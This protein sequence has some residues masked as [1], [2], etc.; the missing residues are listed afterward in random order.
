MDKTAR[1]R[2]TVK[3]YRYALKVSAMFR[4]R[5]PL[6][7]RTPSDEDYLDHKVERTP[8]DRLHINGYVWASLLRRAAERIDG[9]PD[10]FNKIGKYDGTM[11]VSPFWFESTIVPLR[12][13]DI[14]P[15]IR[16]DRRLGTA[17]RGALYSE[18]IVPAGHKIP[19]DF[20]VFLENNDD[21]DEIV[22]SIEKI[23]HLIDD[24]IENIGGNW[25]YGYGRLRFLEGRYR[26]L[27][28]ADDDERGALWLPP[29]SG[30]TIT[31]QRPEVKSPYLKITVNARISD[32][33]MMAIHS[34]L[35]P[36]HFDFASE[37][38][39]PEYPD[40]FVFRSFILG[41]PEDTPSHEVVIPGKAIRQALFS[42]PIERKLRTLGEDICDSIDDKCTCSRCKTHRRNNTKTRRSPDCECKRCLWFGSTDAGGIIAVTDAV[43]EESETEYLRRI[44][45][46]E[47]SMQNVNLFLEEF[48]VKGSF[49]FEILIDMKNNK[50]KT[51]QL[52]KLVTE[53]LE[54]MKG[55]NA[56]EGWHRLGASSTCTGNVI[57]KDWKIT[58]YGRG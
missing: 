12:I 8:D 43:V 22:D 51:D 32:G 17:A 37:E 45:L 11:G 10:V 38:L 48:L 50:E 46:C 30:E 52:I 7:I 55:V 47:H 5:T 42:V 58:D 1:R 39:M 16:I 41:P 56:P 21:V 13:T 53:I 6:V 36:L 25:S 35:P 57:V 31:L 28:L 24:G 2:Q 15:G 54:E 9:L 3:S 20:M 4:L 44:Q 23:F 33:Q 40:H 29:D 34:E 14:R 26:V 27:D 19:V 18:E 49:K